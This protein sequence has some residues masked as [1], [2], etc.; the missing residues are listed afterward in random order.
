MTRNGSTL[1]AALLALPIFTAAASA[2]QFYA[3]VQADG[4]LSVTDSGGA[5]VPIVNGDP[6][7]TRP[8]T[9][10]SDSY[11]FNQLDSDKAELVLTDCATGLGTYDVEILGST[12]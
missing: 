8:D 3:E 1:L 7:G 5:D 10:P 4:S 12:Q 11:Y 9:C 2:Q 6:V